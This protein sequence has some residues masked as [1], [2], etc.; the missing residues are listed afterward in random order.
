MSDNVV[1]RLDETGTPSVVGPFATIDE[2]T[3]FANDLRARW[4]E[5]EIGKVKI[6]GMSPIPDWWKWEA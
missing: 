6:A 4:D 2:A 5:D 3:A 1:I